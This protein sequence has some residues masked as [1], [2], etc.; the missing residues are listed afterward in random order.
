MLELKG[1][2]H[3]MSEQFDARSF[4]VVDLSGLICFLLLFFQ[5]GVS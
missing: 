1:V 3:Q 5:I 2:L 4:L